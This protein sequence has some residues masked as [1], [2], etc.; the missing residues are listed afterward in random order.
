[1]KIESGLLFL[2]VYTLGCSFV[3]ICY[4]WHNNK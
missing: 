2:G 1:L 3:A 4:W